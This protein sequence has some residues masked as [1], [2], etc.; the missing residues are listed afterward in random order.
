MEVGHNI[1]N[2]M[3]TAGEISEIFN[4]YYHNSASIQVMSY[5]KEKVSDPDIKKAIEMAL[6]QS[7]S[8]VAQTT[9]ILN[10]INHPIPQGFTQQDVNINAPR[11]FSDKLMMLYT[12]FLARF[13]LTY[14]SEARACC[15]RSDVRDFFNTAIDS[16][17]KLFNLADEILLNKGMFEKEPIIPIPEKI[18]V[19]KKQSFLNG[20]LGDK[21]TLNAAE[22]NRLYL[23]FHRNALGKAFLIGLC[24]TTKDK[25][26]K[27]YFMRG[28]DISQNH[29]NIA[30]G[31]LDKE[32]LPSPL[33]LDS[34]VTESTET[35]FSDK[36]MLF[37]V[38]SLD[39]LGLGM[40]GISL[41]RV[42][43]KD[44]SIAITRLMTEVALYAEDGFN[45]LIDKEWFER[46]PQA[47][48]R[49]ELI[50]V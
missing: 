5:F 17:I 10:S 16:T 8:Y 24:Q 11:I 32:N 9:A 6:E 31:F 47:T 4:A 20:F 46:M 33:I 25:E 39:A 45:L 50:G 15:A 34:E 40:N 41:S 23:A 21:R 28:K 49:Q 1:E 29:M 7:K 13:G 12:R 30:S 22:I 38:V 3:L 44:L 19:I 2:I 35:I 42:M 37:H 18:D 36:L 26:L 43:R 48:N 14:Y 27:H